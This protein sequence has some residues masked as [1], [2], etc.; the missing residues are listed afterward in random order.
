MTSY[1]RA[2]AC[3]RHRSIRTAEDVCPYIYPLRRLTAPPLPK[4]EALIPNTV[5]HKR[6][7]RGLGHSRKCPNDFFASFFFA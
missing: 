1:C 7:L 6:A 5:H 3:S 2:G 4:G